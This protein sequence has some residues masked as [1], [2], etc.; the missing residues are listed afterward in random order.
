MNIFSNAK[1]AQPFD[2]GQIVFKEGDVGDVMYAVVEGTV[3]LTHGGHVIDKIGEGGF[4]GEMSLVD[5]DG[6]RSATAM[7]ATPAKLVRVDKRHFTFLVQ[8]HP[9]FA[10]Q[11]MKVMADR[12]RHANG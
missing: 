2:A 1:D 3:E 7:A 5:D 9:T 11:V 6:T 4:F 12:I 10:L 8:E